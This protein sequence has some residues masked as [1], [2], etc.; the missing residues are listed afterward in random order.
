MEPTPGTGTLAFNRIVLKLSGEA[1]QGSKSGGV[2]ADVVARFLAV[3]QAGQL[4]ADGSIG[5]P[6]KV[7]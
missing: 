2:D 1:L 6:K 7:A 3:D 5:R 4:G